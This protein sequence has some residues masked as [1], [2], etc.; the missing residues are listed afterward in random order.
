M[1]LGV[2][3]AL[4]GCG[5]SVDTGDPSTAP[6]P[7]TFARIQAQVFDVSCSADSCHSSV[8]QAGDLVLDADNAWDELMYTTP[9]NPV[10]AEHGYMRVLPGRP[11]KSLLLAKLANTLAPGEGVAMPYGAALLSEHTVEVIRAWIAAG[12]PLDGRVPGDDGAPLGSGMGNGEINL[13]P[14]EHGVQLRVT[15]A[16]IP[17]GKEETACHYFK[18]PSA[19][20]LEV[21]RFEIAVSGG[22]H[23][24]HLYRPFQSSLDLPDGSEVCNMAVDF[25]TWELVV[26][27]QLRDTDWQLPPGV[28]F[29][30]RAGEQL[31]MQ[32]HFVNVGSLET[33]GNGKVA[34]NL[35][36][37]EPSQVSAHAGAI[38]GQDK[39]V[40]VPA[41]SIT[42]KAAECVFPN[43]IT[44]MGQTGHY[45]FRGRHFTT[46]RWDDGVRGESIYEYEG[47]D[48]PP[49]LVYDPA[50]SPFFSPGQG[51]Q[52]ECEWVNNSGTDYQFGPFTDTNEHCNWFGFYY[53]T[54]AAN[55][56]ITCVKQNGV[57]TTTVRHSR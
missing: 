34:M 53:P 43:A 37:V 9:A 11:E 50:A 51:L 56:S 22:S 16:P 21:S 17:V 36:A 23:H 35:H 55:E 40:F 14:P 47:Y 44:L 39:D 2:I 3:W 6:Q 32:T 27:T 5:G 41:N 10:A 52:W 30:F 18:L 45:H 4:G 13:P 12:A 24:I 19:I 38:F 7:S 25:D 33:R 15:A 1:V 42:T 46:F 8:G 49:F 54:Q 31:L 26:A 48:D 20:D 29:H 28:A 57:V